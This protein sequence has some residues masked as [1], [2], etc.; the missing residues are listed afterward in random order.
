MGRLWAIPV[1]NIVLQRIRHQPGKYLTIIMI[2][3]VASFFG[4]AMMVVGASFGRTMEQSFAGRYDGADAVA[5]V[6]PTDPENHPLTLGST[7]AVA[8]VPGIAQAAASPFVPVELT[9]VDP[10]PGEEQWPSMT[11]QLWNP[12]TG[13]AGS[14]TGGSQPAADDLGVVLSESTATELGVHAGQSITINPLNLEPE[15]TALPV[16]A[17]YKPDNPVGNVG[18]FATPAA[19]A[20]IAGGPDAAAALPIPMGEFMLRLE[21]GVGPDDFDAL[22]A[23]LAA[24]LGAEPHAV[25]VKTVQQAQR[26]VI[27]EISGSTMSFTAVLWGFVALALVVSA[28]VIATTMSVLITQRSHELAL[29]RCVGATSTQLRRAVLGEGLAVGLIGAVVGTL[30]CAE[31]AY[32][33]RAV[34]PSGVSVVISPLRLLVAA[35]AAVATTVLASIAPAR[36]AASTSAVASLDASR[37]QRFPLLRVGVG[38][39]LLV[40]AVAALAAGA[41]LRS[42]IAGVAGGVTMLLGIVLSARGWVPAGTQV[43]GRLLP[44]TAPALLARDNAVRHPGRTTATASALV[45]GVWLVVTLF[46]GRAVV[47]QFLDGKLDQ[48]VLDQ[49]MV[50]ILA[51]LAA[52]VLVGVMGVMSTMSL[53]VAERS[54]DH[55]L[56]RSLGMTS[57]QLRGSIVAETALITGVALVA[58][59]VLGLF[60]GWAAAAAI[61]DGADSVPFTAPWL[62]LAATAV[63]AILITGAAA[64]MPARR[65]T[66]IS[67]MEGLA[68]QD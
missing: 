58:G 28:V 64:W 48:K 33:L 51:L 59:G 35:L 25:S 49:V 17:V 52:A 20:R 54:R 27:A 56:L 61:L 57:G 65:A 43:L 32:V 63:G 7:E 22:A 37:T 9:P 12:I 11:M 14:I 5:L 66:R 2:V 10:G 68:V 60:T 4:S 13:L 67:P 6:E 50:V 38:S 46:T 55:A 44:S 45:V 39:V 30:V 47:G 40:G 21:P 53:S 24:A 8:A 26:D 15:P 19:L 41:V 16:L 62:Y 3:A 42:P 36:R 23:D 29:V 1:R 34:V 31:L 18:A